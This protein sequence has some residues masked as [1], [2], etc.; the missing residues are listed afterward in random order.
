MTLRVE[1][2]ARPISSDSHVAE[3]PDLYKTYI[4]PK[5]RDRAP[6]VVSDPVR[7]DVYTIPGHNIP[8]PLGLVCAAG[9]NPKD[10]TMSRVTF[11]DMYRGSW[12]PK[13]RIADQ[14]RDKI[15]GELIYPTV[16]MVVCSHPDSE[17]KRA[18]FQAY[19]RWVA[20]FCGAAPTRL[21]GVGQ[22]MIDPNNIDRTI[23]DAMELKKMGFKGAMLP[24]EPEN[25][26]VH[27]YHDPVYDPV[28][29]ALS[30]LG[31]PISFHI[32]TGKT[33]K[34][35]QGETRG[36][37][38]KLMA[39]LQVV[40]TNQDLIGLF[41]FG[42]VFQRNPK[43]KMVSVEADAGW[44]PHFMYRADHG[45]KYHRYWMRM[46]ALEKSPSEYIREN[47]YLTFQDDYTAFELM[48]HMN[49][50]RMLWASDFPHSDSTWPR[51]MQVLEEQTR[52]LSDRE[53]NAVVRDNIVELYN[54]PNAA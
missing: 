39:F 6:H 18:C 26:E 34:L 24:G 1:K 10:V 8:V 43:L 22:L 16:G 30:D 19:N 41:T 7:G 14:D 32:Q 3:P 35:G 42:S 9:K 51:S 46:H 31:L 23:G 4:D 37:K 38:I 11:A 47:V 50:K 45:Y 12:D 40:R 15:G 49:Y 53:Y 13:A 52:N 29:Q 28:W 27:D 5:F 33:N 44:L 2:L 54:L 21:F 48:N 17:Y 20:E 36:G 25:F